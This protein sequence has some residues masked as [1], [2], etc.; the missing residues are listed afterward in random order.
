MAAQHAPPGQPARR[1]GATTPHGRSARHARAWRRERARSSGRTGPPLCGG[2]RPTPEVR[3]VRPSRR[4]IGTATQVSARGGAAVAARRRRASGA[5]LPRCSCGAMRAR[6]P[7]TAR[8]ARSHEV[9]LR[10]PKPRIRL[11]VGDRRPLRRCCCSARTPERVRLRRVQR[12]TMRQHLQETRR[13]RATFSE[14][15]GVALA[16]DRACTR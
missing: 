11:R 6:S 4:P 8:G 12:D 15:L 7:T 2:A 9:L 16:L 14:S 1:S 13:R 10:P 5:P 3:D